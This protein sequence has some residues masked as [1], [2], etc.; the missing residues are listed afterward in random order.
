M[1]SRPLLERA[2]EL[3]NN[4]L[5]FECHDCLEEV[6]ADERGEEKDFLQGLI[7]IS[8]GM[9]H[10]AAGNHQGAVNLLERGVSRLQTFSPERGG[11]DVA[12]LLGK[13]HVC[14][15][16]SRSALGGEEFNWEA[17]DVPRMNVDAVE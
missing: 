9:Y 7:S 10:V 15:E 4:K 1:S 11:L 13:A 14:L 5:Y 2:S 6:W 16:K 3:F 12:S 8:V 17:E